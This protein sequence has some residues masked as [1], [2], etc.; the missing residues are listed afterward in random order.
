MLQT[1][2]VIC[3]STVA[4]TSAPAFGQFACQFARGCGRSRS[5]RCPAPH[6]RVRL[7]TDTAGTLTTHGARGNFQALKR[8]NLTVSQISRRKF[9]MQTRC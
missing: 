2:L 6:V 3:E 7:V 1:T 5:G 9:A 4:R 8:F